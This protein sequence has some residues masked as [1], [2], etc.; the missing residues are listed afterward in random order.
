[1]TFF[2]RNI[3]ISVLVLAVIVG[4]FAVYLSGKT[5]YESMLNMVFNERILVMETL[6]AA[7]LEGDEEVGG[8]ATSTLAQANQQL[9]SLIVSIGTTESGIAS[10]QLIDVAR[11]QVRASAAPSEIGKVVENTDTLTTKRGEVAISLTGTQ[12]RP[13]I[14]LTYLGANNQLLVMDIDRSFFINPAIVVGMLQGVLLLA[15]FGIFGILFYII[16]RKF[17]MRPVSRLREAL[18]ITK[19]PPPKKDEDAKD[20]KKKIQG[21][22]GELLESF[23][24]LS[25]QIEATIAHDQVVAQTKSDFISTTAHQLRTPLSGINWALSSIKDAENL[26]D[27]QRGLLTRALEKTKELVGIVGE[28]LSAA[29][30]EQGKFGFHREELD[31][32]KEIE[33]TIKE[34]H[35]LAQ[36]NNVTLRFDSDREQYP[37]VYVDK[38]RIRWVIRN[39]IENAIRYG[40]EGGEVSVALKQQEASLLVAVKDD[41]IGITPEAQQYIFQRFYRS[42]EARRKRTDGSGLGL[43]IVKNIVNYHGGRIWFESVEGVG[44]TFFFTVPVGGTLATSEKG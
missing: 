31:L 30:I 14:T 28:L 12:E 9:E 41:G 19:E 35:Q 36:Q 40:R 5:V 22:F 11:N 8:T 24:E 15:G 34:E 7:F 4:G 27:E 39:L 26:T 1:M 17:F 20:A 33:T 18:E 16:V 13:L 44:T 25:K 21:G 32:K 3:S 10:F 2:L 29:G 38:E 23:S 6:G 43:Y 37:A 42:P